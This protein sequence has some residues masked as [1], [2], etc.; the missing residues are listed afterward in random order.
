MTDW[1]PSTLFT[2]HTTLILVISVNQ[3][4]IKKKMMQNNLSGF[5]QTNDCDSINGFFHRRQ[6]ARFVMAI[7]YFLSVRWCTAWTKQKTSTWFCLSKQW[8]QEEDMSCQHENSKSLK[9]FVCRQKSTK[10]SKG[11]CIQLGKCPFTLS[12]H[13]GV[14]SPWVVLP[15]GLCL[16][17]LSY[18]LP[19][20]ALLTTAVY[21]LHL[22]LD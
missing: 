1:L 6:S 2:I 19:Q 8:R 4:L 12:K 11:D 15:S 3:K 10:E 5:E 17:Y 21:T 16:S 20:L 13:F 22:I 18:F 14:K 7:K 9:L